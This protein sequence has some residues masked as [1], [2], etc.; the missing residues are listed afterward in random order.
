[1]MK[2]KKNPMTNS[3]GVANFTGA[4]VASVAIQQKICSPVGNAIMMLAAVKKLMP[5]GGSPVVNM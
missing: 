3:S 2:M 4:P 1:M 5:S